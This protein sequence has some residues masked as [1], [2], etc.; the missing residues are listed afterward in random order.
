MVERKPV[1]V[2]GVQASEARLANAVFLQGEG[3]GDALDAVRVRPGVRPA[4]ANPGQ[5]TASSNTVT[6]QPFQA[7]VADSANPASGPYVVT[8]EA[9]QTLPLPAAHASLARIDLVAA[10]VADD[11]FSVNLHVG[12]PASSPV[13][14]ALS[15]T[16][17]PLAQI[18]VKPGQ[19]PAITDLRRFTAAAGGILPVRAA[20]E[21]PTVAQA[22]PGQFA[23]RLDSGELQVFRAGGWQRFKQPRN[24]WQ[25]LQLS[26]GWSPYTAGGVSYHPPGCL[27]GEDGWVHLRGMLKRP[28]G[29]ITATS[30]QIAALPA[31]GPATPVSVPAAQAVLIAMGGGA[32]FRVE[33]STEG[34]VV[35][36]SSTASPVTYP[37]WL[38][39]DGLSF[40]NST[41]FD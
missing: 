33:V 3:A 36:Y 22:S 32:A 38:S 23:Y 10:E 2:D 19:Q 34:K 13:P 40:P 27:V 6:V 24:R 17:L 25:S 1:W 9:V 4:G 12:E 29:T 15:T 37:S 26:S 31:A 28:D 16:Y 7:V 21:L 18:S 20:A 8:L 30:I 14:P 35:L 41:I 5:V 11:G 39:L